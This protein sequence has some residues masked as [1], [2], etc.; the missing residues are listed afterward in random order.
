MATTC[1]RCSCLR[2]LWMSAVRFILSQEE[3][4][5]R[6]RRLVLGIIVLLLVDVLWVGSSE[7]TDFIFKHEGFNKPFFTTYVKTSSFMIYLTGFIFYEPWRLHCTRYNETSSNVSVSVVNQAGE[8]SSLLQTPSPS[9]ETSPVG[10]PLMNESRFEEI[11]DDELSTS[12]SHS[13]DV[14]SS[15]FEIIPKPRRVTFSSVREV[16]QLADHIAEQARIARLP[17]QDDELAHKLPLQQVAKVALIFCFLWFCANCSYQEAI[18][19]TSPAAVNI[20]SS[21]SGLFTLILASVFQSSTSD[22][23]SITKLLA[24]LMS[25]TGIVL[26]TLSD[27]KSKEDSSKRDDRDDNDDSFQSRRRGKENY[28]DSAKDYDS[29]D[30]RGNRKPENLFESYEDI[31]QRKRAQER[32][33]R[34]LDDS[35]SGADRS[36]RLNAPQYKQNSRSDGYLSRRFD[37]DDYDRNFSRNRSRGR[38]EKSFESKRVR[39]HGDEDLDD[40][41]WVK[42][43]R[44]LDYYDDE[45]DEEEL[46]EFEREEKDHR[47]EIV[48]MYQTENLH[49]TKIF[50]EVKTDSSI[51]SQSAPLEGSGVIG[52]SQESRITKA[53][54]QEQY[55]KELQQQMQ[56]QADIKKREKLLH[57]GVEQNSGRPLNSQLDRTPP[58][59]N[60][61]SYPPRSQGYDTSLANHGP[62]SR[63][64]PHPAI[65]SNPY[66]DPYYYYGT[67]EM[68]AGPSLGGA[69]NS[70]RGTGQAGMAGLRL[71]A[72]ISGGAQLQSRDAHSTRNQAYTTPTPAAFPYRVGVSSALVPA[73]SPQGV[74]AALEQ[75]ELIQDQMTRR[76]RLNKLIRKN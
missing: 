40:D 73:C 8:N 67:L 1:Y 41:S 54:K 75:W 20:L 11:T 45:E 24:V 34:G 61:G 13:V 29:Q 16:R 3:G 57:L 10:T 62:S 48:L 19:H 63:P 31:L 74:I 32:R 25:I 2:S 58:D 64:P 21:S 59:A 51:R 56:E 6:K 72:G 38:K 17:Y 22:K 30:R 14:A 44:R 35:D 65:H 39:F 70:P 28:D 43:R 60:R 26:V 49:K 69:M 18:S 5:R 50:S 66:D 55:K 37:D 46:L 76:R 15:S 7:L 33:Y 9:R 68:G 71:D 27:S 47:E 36:M 23:F 53:K 12:R 52:G 4:I 42:P